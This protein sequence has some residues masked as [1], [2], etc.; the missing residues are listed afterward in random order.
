MEYGD[1]DSVEG[2]MRVLIL[3]VAVVALCVAGYAVLSAKT[4]FSADALGRSLAGEA[5]VDRWLRCEGRG[6]GWRC[7]E[8]RGDWNEYRV[9]RTDGKCRK[10]RRVRQSRTDP[11]PP[12]LEGCVDAWEA[13]SN[14]ETLGSDR[15]D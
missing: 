4:E 3:A 10:A 9:R 1:G 2:V 7:A 11:L 5:Q 12:H 15:Y 6:A 13:I 14:W 8:S